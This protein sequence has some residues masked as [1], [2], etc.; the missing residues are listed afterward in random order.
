MLRLAMLLR[1]VM[2]VASLGTAL[3]SLVMFWEGGSR[4]LHAASAVAENLGGKIAIAQVMGGTDAFLFGVVLIIFAYNIA[5]GFVLALDKAERR[6]FPKWMRPS[7]LHELKTTL[8]SVT[9][10]YLVVDFATDWAES[11]IIDSWTAL[12]KPISI[13]LIAA[14]LRL[15]ASQQEPRLRRI[16]RPG[17]RAPSPAAQTP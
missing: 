9:L 17:V 3:G 14:A 1:Y 15:M 4:M 12:V 13:L 6:A 8:V 2:L 11:T 5:F 7:S 16:R 10:V